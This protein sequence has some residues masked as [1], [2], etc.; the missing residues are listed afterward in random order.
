MQIY[1]CLTW[2]LTGLRDHYFKIESIATSIG[3]SSSFT[4]V[5]VYLRK[6]FTDRLN[7]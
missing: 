6:A 5:V 2:L 7:I 3:Y 1:F 4:V